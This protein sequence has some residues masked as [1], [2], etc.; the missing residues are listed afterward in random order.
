VLNVATLPTDVPTLHHLLLEQQH[1]IE[2]LK[3]NLHL[4]LHRQ[5]GP[6]NEYVNVDQFGLFAGDAD[7]SALIEVLDSEAGITD[8]APDKPGDSESQAPATRKKAV[9]VLKDLAREIVEQDLPEADKTCTCCGERLSFIG[10]EASEHLAYCPASLKII[11]TRRKKYACESCHGEVKRAALPKDVPLAKSMASSSLLAFLIVA[12][13]ADGLPLYRISKRLERLGIELS[14]A[15]MSDWLIQC[16]VLLTDL[17]R[18]MIRKVLD[19]GHVFTDDTVLPLQN[20]DPTRRT[21]TKARL[22]VYA[23]SRR[24]HTPLVVYEFSRSRSQEAPLNLLADYRGY[25]QADAFPGYDRLYGD[26]QIQE[27]AC[28]VH[29]RRKYVEVTELMR[30]PGRAHEALRFIKELYRIERQIRTLSDEERYAERQSRSV[31]VLNAFKAWLDI[32]VHAVLPK[33]ALGTAVLYT[34]KNWDALCRYTDAG[35]LE[36]DNN[37]AEQCLRPVALGRKNF[38]FVGS[39]RAGHAAAIYYSLVES[40]KVNRVNPLTYLTYVLANVRNKSMT[41]QTPD[42]FTASNIAHVG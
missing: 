30:E 36:P 18:R 2:T 3:A 12:K 21:T 37:Y 24:R 13:F 14:D 4:A 27:V 33:S 25:V 7:S 5:F 8:A 34:L 9:R 42:E 35:Y 6:R 31:P 38:L 26:P 15:L 29:C 39:E 1:M 41:L 40:C 22:W 16:A 17:H 32:Q 23:R 20:V 28:W 11:E 10:C 19:S